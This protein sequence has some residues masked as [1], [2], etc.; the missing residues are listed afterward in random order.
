[1]SFISYL[2]D[3]ISNLSGVGVGSVLSIHVTFANFAPWF[4]ALSE[5]LKMYSPFS[6]N[7]CVFPPSTVTSSSLKLIVAITSWFV[8]LSVL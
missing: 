7:A 3:V 6:V 1:M 5:Y 4:P 8:A 2:P